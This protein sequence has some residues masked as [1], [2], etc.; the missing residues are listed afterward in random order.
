MYD[1]S[2][3][4]KTILLALLVLL[5]LPL[6]SNAQD[7]ETARVFLVEQAH[8]NRAQMATVQE[9][10][11]F[12]LALKPTDDDMVAANEGF[13]LYASQA[14][15]PDCSDRYTVCVVTARADFETNPPRNL[16]VF[17]I[18]AGGYI[19]ISNCTCADNP[20][21]MFTESDECILDLDLTAPIIR[22]GEACKGE[23]CC[24]LRSIL[25]DEEGN[26]VVWN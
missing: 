4:M 10:R 18:D 22:F 7:R 1:P 14:S 11:V 25:I 15:T 5:V 8:V 9:H 21:Y 16:D 17:V 3:P 24:R 12:S 6:Q 19:Q 2:K 23:S 20:D 13:V 26:S